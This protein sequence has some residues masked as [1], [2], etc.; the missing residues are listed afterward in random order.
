MRLGVLAWLGE[1]RAAAQWAPLLDAL[2]SRLPA[3]SLQARYLDLDAMDTAV[4]RGELDFV[5]TNPGHYVALEARHGVSR[6]ATQQIAAG[7]DSAHA[8]AATVIV[9]ATDSTRRRLADLRD[10]RLAMVTPQAFG[11]YQV[12]WGELKRA[13]VD[14]ETGALTLRPT[15]YPMTRVVDAL[16]AGQAD[17]GVLRACLLEALQRTGQVRPGEFRVLSPQHH[18]G[19]PCQRSSPIYPGW[20]FAAAHD[21]PPALS[22]AVLLALLQE[23]PSVHERLLRIFGAAKWPAR[24]LLTHPGV[25]DELAGHQLY[26]E[27]FDPVQF[28][29]ELEARKKSLTSTGEDDD[30][31]LLNLLRRAHHAETFRTLARDVDGVLTVEQVA[32][33]LSALA[34]TVLRITGRCALQRRAGRADH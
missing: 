16:R 27:R 13:G 23:R 9:P 12:I 19:E 3:H 2:A 33:D 20:A 28:E 18:A 5:I 8:V 26:E 25:I 10:A 22:R 34:D 29:A 24:Y 4:A 30:E 14:P 31:E 11:G 21:T 15:G 7:H 32:D 6:I 1:D 17:A